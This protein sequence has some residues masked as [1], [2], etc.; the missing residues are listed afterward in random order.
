MPHNEDDWEAHWGTVGNGVRVENPANNYRARLVMESIGR[1]RE[2]S[3]IVDIGCG[4]GT[5]TRLVASRYPHCEVIGIEPSQEG[6][7]RAVEIG[8]SGGSRARFMRG[9]VLDPD[10]ERKSEVERATAVICSEVLEHL[11]NPVELLVRIRQVILAEG[12]YVIITVPGGPRSAFDRAIG[13]RMHFTR[14]RCMVMLKWAGYE[15]QVVA[16]A[17]FPFFNL[18]KCLVILRGDK[19]MVD[20]STSDGKPGSVASRMVLRWF[21]RLFNFNVRDSVLGWQ[22]CAIGRAPSPRREGGRDTV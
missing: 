7:R 9:N 6:I 14:G 20:L 5:L 8:Q 18:Y 10:F 1:M 19:V 22:L 11:D 2:G 12:G 4:Q 21:D 15:A 17:G 16:R 3:R 13:H